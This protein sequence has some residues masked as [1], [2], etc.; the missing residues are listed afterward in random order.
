MC[1][2]IFLTVVLVT[3]VAGPLVGLWAAEPVT[4]PVQKTE[5]PA[6]GKAPTTASRPA[7]KPAAGNDKPDGSDQPPQLRFLAWQDV[8]KD[9]AWKP[10]GELVKDE[11]DSIAL[12]RVGPTP[13]TGYSHGE[14]VRFLRLWFSHPDLDRSASA[15]V[16]FKDASG[17]P[18]PNS[19]GGVGS[20]ISP[21]GA[22]GST[23]GLGWVMVTAAPCR[24]KDV[25]PKSVDVVLTYILEPWK[26]TGTVNG[27]FEGPVL[28]DGY[29]VI[30]AKEGPNDRRDDGSVK[31]TLR[32]GHRDDGDDS[33]TVRSIVAVTFDGRELSHDEASY[34]MSVAGEAEGSLAFYVPQSEIKLFRFRARTFRK[35]TFQSVSLEPGTITAPLVVTPPDDRPP[36]TAPAKNP[37]TKPATK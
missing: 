10:N 5:Q 2:G 1:V 8:D 36:V 4:R 25:P 32:F 11:A 15:S 23:D 3:V 13:M 16:T 14:P 20:A 6:T 31:T 24:E 12:R 29:V 27:V 33:R 19:G 34:S 7:S 21:R 30:E 17:K 18:L 9:K 26:E 28:V 37:T 35:V 22:E